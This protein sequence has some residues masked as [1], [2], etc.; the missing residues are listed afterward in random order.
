MQ[1]LLI[2]VASLQ[3]QELP[4]Q[5][6]SHQRTSDMTEFT[7]MGPSGLFFYVFLVLLLNCFDITSLFVSEHL[8]GHDYFIKA[9]GI[10]S[11]RQ[12]GIGHYE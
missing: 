12:Q 6:N 11:M 5:Q 9:D 1:I 7:H 8:L 2:L 3:E 4:M 10:A